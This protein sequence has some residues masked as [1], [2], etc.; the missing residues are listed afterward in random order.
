MSN[1]FQRWLVLELMRPIVLIG[2][3]IEKIGK[4]FFGPRAIRASIQR[5]HQ[6]A[7]EIRQQLPF[8]FNEYNGRI[9]ADESL[10][11]PHPF[12]Y[13]VVIVELE[14]F[15]LRFIRGRGELA[16][17]VAAMGVPDGWEDL[18]IVLELLG[19]YEAKSRLILLL[20]DVE[21]MLKP[22]MGRVREAFSPSQYTDLKPQLLQAREYERTVARQLSAEINRRLYG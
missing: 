18:P 13:A 6:F 14:N 17:Q 5:E 4:P 7:E 16:V 20:S 21:T 22:R 3:I 9:V 10:A 1:R 2:S 11:H 19:G 8:L 12:D 15:C